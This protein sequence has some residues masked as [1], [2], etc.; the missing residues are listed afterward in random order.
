M[1]AARRMQ[2]EFEFESVARPGS[3]VLDGRQVDVGLRFCANSL[4]DEVPSAGRAS[5][6]PT[7]AVQRVLFQRRGELSA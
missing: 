6:P 1:S 2:P 4:Q 7:R 3:S 5:D